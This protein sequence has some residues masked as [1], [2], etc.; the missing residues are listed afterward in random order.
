MSI[1]KQEVIKIKDEAHNIELQIK[2][3]KKDKYTS[4]VQVKKGNQ[5]DPAKV[6]ITFKRKESNSD[7][8]SDSDC[9]QIK[10]QKKP[11][12]T[13]LVKYRTER[14]KDDDLPPV[15]EWIISGINIPQTLSSKNVL[16][17]RIDFSFGSKKYIW[18]SV[19]SLTELG[20]GTK[21]VNKILTLVKKM[22]CCFLTGEVLKTFM[23]RLRQIPYD[24]IQFRPQYATSACYLYPLE[25]SMD[26]IKK[27]I[28]KPIET[29]IATSASILT[30]AIGNTISALSTTENEAVNTIS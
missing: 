6:T 26:V 22:N 7:T 19:A 10:K 4:D 2:I 13:P 20:V 11:T 3:T 15:S 27:T 12:V 17:V 30:T 18:F 23:A 25:E 28:P 16:T 5:N 29:V 14:I 21:E 1:T 8:E 24:T 9:Y